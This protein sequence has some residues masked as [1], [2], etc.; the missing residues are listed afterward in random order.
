MIEVIAQPSAGVVNVGG[1]LLTP[2]EAY[3]MARSLIAAADKVCAEVHRDCGGKCG[4][5]DR[6]KLRTSQQLT[7]SARLAKIKAA[8]NEARSA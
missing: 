6:P 2:D 1:R 7:R 5:P 3:R 8:I 4:A